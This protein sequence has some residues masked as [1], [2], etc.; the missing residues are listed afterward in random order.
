M[1]N[2]H[3]WDGIEGGYGHIY[4]VLQ[5]NWSY[6]I[7]DRGTVYYTPREG[8]DLLIWCPA[9]DLR[10]HLRQLDQ[11]KACTDPDFRFKAA[12]PRRQSS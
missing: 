12:G 1:K 3:A 5:S 2:L 7:D 4:D 11:I 6:W 8:G 9:K 10:R